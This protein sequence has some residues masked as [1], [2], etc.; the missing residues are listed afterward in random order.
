VVVAAKAV[1]AALQ[2]QQIKVAVVELR[3][4]QVILAQA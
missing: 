1:L 2:Q 4:H 3:R